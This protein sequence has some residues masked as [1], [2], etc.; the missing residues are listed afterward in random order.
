VLLTSEV[1]AAAAAVALESRLGPVE[2]TVREQLGGSERST[3]VRAIARDV[4]GRRHRVA[5]EACMPIQEY[6]E[7]RVFG[8]VRPRVDQRS[9]RA[10][11]NQPPLPIAE[12]MPLGKSA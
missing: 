9:K 5:D 10:A 7:L 4:D 2:V 3:V 1:L 11:R 6:L 12:E 8:R